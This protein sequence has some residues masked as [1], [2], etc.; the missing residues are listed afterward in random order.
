MR[1]PA[2]MPEKPAPTAHTHHGV[3]SCVKGGK[4]A[5]Q[6]TH[7]DLQLATR[8]ADRVVLEDERGRVESARETGEGVE[9]DADP[10]WERRR[11]SDA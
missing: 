1:I 9:V 6:R 5:R 10:A 2:M 8:L 4:V 7:G 11:V 3:S